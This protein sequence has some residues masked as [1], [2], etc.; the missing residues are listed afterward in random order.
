MVVDDEYLSQEPARR[1]TFRWILD[2][3]E[4]VVPSA[5]SVLE[6][7]SNVGLFLTVAGEAGWRAKGVEPSAW[8]VSEGVDRFGV[9]LVAGTVESYEDAGR[10]PVVAMFDVL[11]HVNDPCEAL[12][13]VVDLLEPDG[14]L[15]LSTVDTNSL[16][17]RIRRGRWPWYIRSHLHYFTFATLSDLLAERGLEIV[18]WKNVP[19]S[20][21]LSYILHKGGWADGTVG[22]L[23][24]RVP[25]LGKVRIPAGWLGDIKLVVARRTGSV[26][27]AEG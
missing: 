12:A 9:D 6:F 5:R 4:S 15:A 18:V 16:H 17:S 19:R 7:G 25:A 13:R 1:E 8:S 20:F 3:I 11:E 21:K 23:I 2:Q 22:S 24:G 27:R 10:W 14:V 26:E